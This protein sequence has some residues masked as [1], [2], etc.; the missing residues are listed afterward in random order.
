MEESKEQVIC[1]Y[2]ENIIDNPTKDHVFPKHEIR[3]C[4]KN[5]EELPEGIDL[6]DNI[7]IA[8]LECNINKGA[9]N[10]ESFKMLGVKKIRHLKKQLQG[11]MMKNKVKKVKS[12]YRKK[13]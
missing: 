3:K 1:H 11:R 13:H 4:A 9:K 12:K 7:V 10:Y 2:C 5:G 8:C 6:R